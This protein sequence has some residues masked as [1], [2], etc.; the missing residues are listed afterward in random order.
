[1]V[2]SPCFF[3]D[4]VADDVAEACH[5][6]K[7]AGARSVE[8]RSRVYGR[9]IDELSDA[10]LRQLRRLL[11]TVGMSTACIASSFGKCDLENDAEW[12]EHKE[13]LR[14]SIRAAQALDTDIVRVFPFWTPDHRELPRPDL[15]AFLGRIVAKLSWAVSLAESEGVLLCFETE[16][17]TNSGTCAEVRRIVDALGP[18]PALGVTWDV[19]NAWFAG[20]EHPLT[21]AYPLIRG[22]VRHV[23]V[24]PNLAGNIETVGDSD[25]SYAAVLAALCSDGYHG[26]ASIEHWGEPADM[27]RGVA[28]LSRLLSALA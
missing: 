28:Q 18:S 21:E 10:E 1:V 24:K 11:D 2:I 22:L 13:I 12:A 25:V 4:E 14:G 20:R 19:N 15:S 27:L 9:R 6:G 8:L 16:P 5:L 23:H 3:T 17:S 26:S 7:A